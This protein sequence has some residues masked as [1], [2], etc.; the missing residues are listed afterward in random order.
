LKRMGMKKAPSYRVVVA[1]ER[2]PR[3]GRFIEEIGYYNPMTEPAE[4]KIDAEKA[5]KWIKN[6]AQPTDTV[7]AL[8]K[9]SGIID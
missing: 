7:R 3:D 1:D 9:K 8:L 2:M 4:V 6:G 5:Q